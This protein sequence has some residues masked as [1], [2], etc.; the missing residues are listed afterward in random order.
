MIVWI[1]V[2]NPDDKLCQTIWAE[3][4]K[5][6]ESVVLSHAL[7]KYSTMVHSLPTAPLMNC[8]WCIGIPEEGFMKENLMRELSKIASRFK[9]DSITWYECSSSQLI[10]GE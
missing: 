7:I 10:L 1:S 9:L 3:V 5:S 2:D 6:V 8:H 4:I